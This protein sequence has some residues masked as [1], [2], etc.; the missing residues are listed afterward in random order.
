MDRELMELAILQVFFWAAIAFGLVAL[1]HKKLH[2]ISPLF[3][4]SFPKPSDDEVE[5]LF[6]QAE[7][8]RDT[9]GIYGGMPIYL[10]VEIEG[11]PYRFD[12]LLVSGDLVIMERGE[13]CVAPGL[14]YREY[15][16]P[17]V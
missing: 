15:Q 9:I 16:P 6:V 14:V 1:K 10:F 8:G 7:N 3:H 12:R 11:K 4:T 13:R 17:S 5:S 2:D